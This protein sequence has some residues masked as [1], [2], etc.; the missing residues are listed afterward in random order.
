[1]QLLFESR[2]DINIAGKVY[3]FQ[4][5]PV[6]HPDPVLGPDSFVDGAGTSIYG[7]VLRDAYDNIEINC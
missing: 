3:F 7:S 1:M 6:I 4:R 2:T 5:K